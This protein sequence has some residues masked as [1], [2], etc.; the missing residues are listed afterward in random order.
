MEFLFLSFA[1]TKKLKLLK[2][3]FQNFEFIHHLVPMFEYISDVE[4]KHRHDS[5][6]FDQK[7]HSIHSV[8]D[9]TIQ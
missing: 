8:L 3:W 2:K 5:R 4:V 9:G 7:F 6:N 1:K